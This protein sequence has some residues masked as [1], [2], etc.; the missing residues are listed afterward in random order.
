MLKRFDGPRGQVHTL[1]HESAV[2][3]GNRPGDPHVRDVMV[4]TP[5]GYDDTRDYPLLVDLIGY[6]GSGRSH[7]NWKPFGLNLP[8]RLDILLA[9][10]KIGPMVVA[11][12]DC[13][14]AYGGNQYIDSTATGPYMT[15]LCDE[16]VPFVESRF[17]IRKNVRGV[18]GKSSGGYGAM[19]HGMMRPDVWNAIASH[20]GDAYWEWLFLPVL[21]RLLNRLRSVGF[22]TERLL[23]QIHASEKV[24][25]GD[26]DVIM[27]LGMAAHYDPDPSAPLGFH[28]PIDA[29]GRLRED[30]WANWLKW[31]TARMVDHHGDAIRSLRGWY[32][33]CGDHDQYNIHWG[34]KLIHESLDR[35][36][37]EHVYEE[38][39]DN[40]SDVDYRMNVSLPWLWRTLTS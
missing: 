19:V 21:P 2:L 4:Y 13:F 1:R 3:R 10:G 27:A 12:P 6:A 17:P 31:D 25:S 26:V 15:Y 23:A 14:T 24:S 20:S 22:D 30:R 32:L 9:E 29:S 35:Q 38:F 37:I 8:E 18:F 36:G 40:H 11:L 28:L 34:T 16:I 33:D 39:S 7:T 5:P